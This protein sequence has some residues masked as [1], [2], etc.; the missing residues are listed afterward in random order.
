MLGVFGFG[1]VSYPV[2]ILSDKTGQKNIIFSGLIAFS[3]VYAL[4][5]FVSSWWAFAILFLVYGFY[6]AATEGISKALISNIVDK[7]EMATAFGFYNSFA[8]IATM[9]ASTIAGLIWFNFSPQATFIISAVCVSITAM[10][11]KV[12]GVQKK[13]ENRI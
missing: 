8:S 2:G 11:I 12:F 7:T 1:L 9:L 10:F 5:G 13:Q 6:A 3:I 4:F